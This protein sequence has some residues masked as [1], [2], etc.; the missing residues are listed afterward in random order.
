MRYY[1][2]ASGD[3]TN[4]RYEQ[5]QHKEEQESVLFL[6]SMERIRAFNLSIANEC[7]MH[8]R[9]EIGG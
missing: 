7:P 4:D 5:F 2:S 8:L 9:G 1:E 3:V 6:H